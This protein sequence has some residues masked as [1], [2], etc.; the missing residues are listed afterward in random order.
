MVKNMNERI[1]CEVCSLNEAVVK[2][3][4]TDPYTGDIATHYV[5]VS[6]YL[7][8]DFW[9][10]RLLEAQSKKQKIKV[11]R[12]IYGRNWKSHIIKK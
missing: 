5:C 8:S 12:E 1:K 4:R 3:Y 11:L 7:L 6:C 2:D 10:W 9:Y